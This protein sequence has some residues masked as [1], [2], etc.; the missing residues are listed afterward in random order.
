MMKEPDV[1]A[2]ERIEAVVDLK[3]HE[4]LLPLVAKSMSDVVPK[5]F[6]AGIVDAP[7]MLSAWAVAVGAAVCTYL[8]Q[9]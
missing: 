4:K 1:G 2:N 5:T 8:P 3:V 9:M 7:E 6:D